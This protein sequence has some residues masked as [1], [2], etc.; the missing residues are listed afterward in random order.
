LLSVVTESKPK[1]WRK[2][3]AEQEAGKHKIGRFCRE[4]RGLNS[5]IVGFLTT[6][7]VTCVF[8]L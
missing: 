7:Q 6:L 5:K 2:L 3:I 4:R 8:L 1:Y